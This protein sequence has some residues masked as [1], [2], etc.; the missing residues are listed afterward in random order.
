VA[1]LD[2]PHPA[3]PAAVAALRALGYV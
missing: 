1:A 2:R 3:D